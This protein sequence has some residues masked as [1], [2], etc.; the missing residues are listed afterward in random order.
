MID[1]QKKN[2][3]DRIKDYAHRKL[4]TTKDKYPAITARLG[5]KW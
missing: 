3:N 5:Y 1:R 2:K 4:A